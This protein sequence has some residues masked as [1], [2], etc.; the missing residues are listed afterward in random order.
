[1]N[2]DTSLLIILVSMFAFVI[3]AVLSAGNISEAFSAAVYSSVYSQMNNSENNAYDNI[4][5]EGR[6]VHQ[7]MCTNQGRRNNMYALG[8]KNITAQSSA[9]SSAQHSAQPTPPEW[10]H[11]P[12]VNFYVAES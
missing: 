12:R 5:N 3:P 10:S 1:M 4:I 7:D 2:R 6:C 9:Q 11:E 8:E